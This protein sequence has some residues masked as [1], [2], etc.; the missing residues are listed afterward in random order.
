MMDKIYFH[1]G[2]FYRSQIHGSRRINIADPDWVRPLTTVELQ[3]GQPY[4]TG[5]EIVENTTDE[6]MILKNVPDWRVPPDMIEI[7]NPACSIP[8]DAVEISSD[9]HAALLDGQASGKRIVAGGDGRPELADQPEPTAEDLA[10]AARFK[11]DYLLTACD[12][13]VI[14]AQEAGEAVPDCWRAYRQALR[15]ITNQAGFP[16]AISWPEPPQ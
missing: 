10:T 1:D 4:D 7:D 13:V 9:E 6:V 12:W 11:R 5:T 3:P 2:G 15:D 8:A 16:S 14:K